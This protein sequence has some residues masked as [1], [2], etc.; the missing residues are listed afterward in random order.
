M[1]DRRPL[2]ALAGHWRSRGQTVATASEP[3]IDV[4][5]TDTYTWLA[6]GHFLIHRVDVRMGEERVEVIEMIGPYDEASRTCPMRSFDSHGGFV[7]MLAR[8]DDGGVWTFEGETER[9]TLTI[10]EDGGA[11]AA[12][13]ERR[14]EDATWRHWM[15]MAFTREG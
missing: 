15:D 13:W 9:A 10:A 5:G 6:G 14:G 4:A 12:A 8:V 2:D 3:A 7:T 11:M 1:K